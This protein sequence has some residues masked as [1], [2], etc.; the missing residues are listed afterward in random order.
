LWLEEAFG[1]GCPYRAGLADQKSP[2]CLGAPAAAAMP[3]NTAGETRRAAFP[4]F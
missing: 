2:Q 3:R 1:S 4:Y